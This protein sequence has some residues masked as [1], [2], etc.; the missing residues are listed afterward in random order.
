MSQTEHI[1][2]LHILLCLQ[3]ALMP[4]GHS[5]FADDTIDRGKLVAVERCASCHDVTEAGQFKQEPPSFAAIAAY[6]SI[7]Q[8]VARI[9]A[10]LVH[11]APLTEIGLACPAP[12]ACFALSSAELADLVAYFGSLGDLAARGGR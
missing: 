4:V 5:A 11:A 8:I 7:E 12:G 9:S 6:R 2:G 1:R 10:P 3:F